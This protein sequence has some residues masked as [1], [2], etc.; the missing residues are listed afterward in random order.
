MARE[1]EGEVR[2]PAK[3]EEEDVVVPLSFCGGAGCRDRSIGSE[4]VVFKS[5]L[6]FA[7]AS[8][9]AGAKEWVG[10]G[11]S[12]SEE[13]VLFSS[14]SWSSSRRRRFSCFI[15]SRF[16]WIEVLSACRWEVI[17]MVDASCSRRRRRVRAYSTF[18]FRQWCPERGQ[19]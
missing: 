7:C 10:D 11:S 6:A 3:R 1:R 16:V 17:L 15:R 14:S 19:W 9:R 2:R 13:E 12:S 18:C 5:M 4:G 8:V